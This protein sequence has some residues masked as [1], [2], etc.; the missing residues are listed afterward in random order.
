MITYDRLFIAGSWEAPSDPGLLDIRSPHDQSVI[1]RAAQAR[2]ADVDRAV[3]AARAAFD[4]GPWPRTAPA[5]R[6]AVLRRLNALR[7]EEAEEIAGLIS[8]ENGSAAWFTRAGQPGLTRQAEAYL[9]AAEAFGWE[10]TLESGS[11]V[12]TVVRREP[13]GVVAAVIPWN[14]PFSSAMAKIVP[15][16]LAGNTVVL[17]VSP[18]NSLSMGLLAGLLE[19]SGL[20]DGVI[21]VLPADRETSEYLVT[22]RDVDKIAFTGSTRAGRRIAALAGERLKRVSL[23]LGGKSAAILLPDADVDRAVQGLRFA[24]LLNNGE[25]CIAQTRVLAPRGRYEEVVTGLKGLVESLKV[26]DPADPDTFIGPMIRR[27]QQQRVRD[28]IEAGIA[29]GARLVTGGPGIPPGLERGNYVTPTV[30]AD[31]D[32]SMRIAREEIFGPVLVVI[33]YED[34]DEAVRIANDSEYGLS[35]GVW[36]ADDAHA[37]EVARRLRTGTVTVNGAAIS[38]DGPFGGYKASGIGREYGAVGL[39]QYVEHKSVTLPASAA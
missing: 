14:S 27:D 34:E 17:K 22:H 30:F 18:E 15:A 19:R 9:R 29:E 31:V 37:L 38:F 5:D 1:G 35:G 36:S 28:Y 13:V 39:A 24:S 4:E 2:P 12:R 6:I 25:S 3:A 8:A 32:N 21:S 10:E 20:P 11:A 23:E 16:L 26:G 7:E 33:P